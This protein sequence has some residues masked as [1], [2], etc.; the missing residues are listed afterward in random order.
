MEIQNKTNATYVAVADSNSETTKRLAIYAYAVILAS[1]TLAILIVYMKYRR[2]GY[3]LA[4]V[5]PN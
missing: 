4:S 1:L 3:T 2:S 5:V